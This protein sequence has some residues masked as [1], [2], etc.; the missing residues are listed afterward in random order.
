[1]LSNRL[2]GVGTAVYVSAD[3]FHAT[4]LHIIRDRLQVVSI[5][6]D[7]LSRRFQQGELDAYF[8]VS[9]HPRP[10]HIVAGPG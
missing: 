7:H 5:E 4:A 1:M 8:A 9:K 2:C 6:D 10:I 3:R